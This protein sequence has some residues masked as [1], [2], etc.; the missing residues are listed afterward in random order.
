MRFKL[1]TLMLRIAKRERFR[2]RPSDL[3]STRAIHRATLWA[4][5]FL[6]FVSLIN[7][8]C[9][10][11]RLGCYVPKTKPTQLASGPNLFWLLLYLQNSLLAPL[12]NGSKNYSNMNRHSES[13]PAMY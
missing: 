7:D 13:W 10:T 5:A 12:Q 6:I 9:L 8:P 3:W 2:E 4:G 1:S 11:S